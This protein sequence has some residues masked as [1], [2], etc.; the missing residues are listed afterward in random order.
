MVS[1]PLAWQVAGN[2]SVLI[3]GVS[4]KG[5]VQSIGCDGKFTRPGKKTTPTI[6]RIVSTRDTW[7]PCG[8]LDEFELSTIYLKTEEYEDKFECLAVLPKGRIK[9]Y[10]YTFEG[11]SRGYSR[12]AA[13]NKYAVEY[14][15]I[16]N[17]KIDCSKVK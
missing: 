1:Q 10:A 8:M 4:K 6:D 13:S 14:Q 15:L 16:R 17:S 7:T 2:Y 3:N 5:R 9:G 11:E 12:R